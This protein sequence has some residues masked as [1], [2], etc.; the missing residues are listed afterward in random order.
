[1]A[2]LNFI[3][4]FEEMVAAA[5][6]TL[7]GNWPAVADIASSSFKTLAQALVDI[8]QMKN[9]GTISDEQAKLLLNMHK[10]TSK[11]VLLTVDVIDI[12]KAEAV[13]NAALSAIRIPVNA[14]LGFQIL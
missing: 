13:I 9:D 7:A 4:I 6:T 1:M 10:N 2:K 11:I 8:E 5:R 12:I 3:T 14:A